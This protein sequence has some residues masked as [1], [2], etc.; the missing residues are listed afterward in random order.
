GRSSE[1]KCLRDGDD[2]MKK[3][4]HKGEIIN[5]RECAKRCARFMKSIKYTGQLE[6]ICRGYHE[7][8]CVYYPENSE[9]ECDSLDNL[10]ESHFRKVKRAKSQQIHIV[11]A[12]SIGLACEIV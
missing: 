1:Y 11:E 6:V 8:S 3:C 2:S 12:S 9:I 10:E 7:C 5:E 4:V